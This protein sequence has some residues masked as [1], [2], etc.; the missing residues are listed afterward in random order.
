MTFFTVK[1]SAKFKDMYPMGIAL[2][3]ILLISE[4]LKIPMATV[5]AHFLNKLAFITNK[6]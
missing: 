5:E 4:K 2:S 6:R 3:L 1:I